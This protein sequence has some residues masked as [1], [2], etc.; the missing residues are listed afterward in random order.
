MLQELKVENIKCSG[1]A[2]SIIKKLGK[3]PGVKEVKVDHEQGL[4]SVEHEERDGMLAKIKSALKEMGYAEVGQ[5][6]F[7]DKAKSY[8]S[9]AIGKMSA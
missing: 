2:G 6:T 1:C 7:I 5:G 9:C 8:V 4:V 3:L